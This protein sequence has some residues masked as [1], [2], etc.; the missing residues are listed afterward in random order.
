MTLSIVVFLLV[1]FS[2]IC[3]S[4]W[5]YSKGYSV[6]IRDAKQA[7]RDEALNRCKLSSQDV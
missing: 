1:L 4:I 5:G 7:T 3:G 2:F 6:N